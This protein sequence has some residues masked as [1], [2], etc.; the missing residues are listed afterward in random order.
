MFVTRGVQT[1]GVH[2]GEE[3]SDA[4]LG[5][6]ILEFYGRPGVAEADRGEAWR[7]FCA[8]VAG[9]P[10]RRYRPEK[11]A[12]VFRETDDSGTWCVVAGYISDGIPVP[13]EPA[14]DFPQRLGAVVRREL[15]ALAPHWPRVR[16]AV[17]MTTATGRWVV[18]PHDDRT[19]AGPAH[20]V[21]AAPG[22]LLT[23]VR[24]A[25]ADSGGAAMP[26]ADSL[27][28]AG[29]D[30]RLLHGCA[31]VLFDELADGSV[32]LIGEGSAAN[33]PVAE[34][35]W[36]GRADDL[37]TACDEAAR[38]L[39][40]L[41]VEHLPPGTPS[42]TSFGIKR[43]W[44]A[45]RGTSVEE[46]AAAVGLTGARP[47]GWD[48]GV[49]AADDEQ[50]FVTPPIAGW[51]LVV[52]TVHVHG[53]E[54]VAQLSA[55]LGAEV[56]YFGNHRVS[57]YAEWARAVDGRLV[58]HVLCGESLAPGVH[59][60]EEGVPTPVEV[61]I[62]FSATDPGAVWA[63]ED[64]VLRVAGAWSID[65]VTLDVVESSPRDGLLGRFDAAG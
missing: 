28:A 41:P 22:P 61:E 1:T 6:A 9:V 58:R 60:E 26:W 29:I 35:T 7:T 63:D 56:Q 62:G 31:R 45:V 27:A 19:V 57:D 55:R 33:R 65:P 34:R 5:E 53:A 64:D 10:V 30:P 16:S 11:S 38:M 50:V 49:A 54:S 37:P 14:V 13:V 20:A 23:A 21:D 4:E 48:E 32:R 46:V 47:A 52:N 17:I 40:E 8:D 18:V 59:A 36:T 25:L 39:A 44:L 51:I 24:A 12:R 42:G 43:T 2:V 15:A 3:L